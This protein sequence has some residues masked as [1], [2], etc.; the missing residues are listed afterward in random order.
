MYDLKELSYDE[1][2]DRGI[3]YAGSVEL[4]RVSIRDHIFVLVQ[5]KLF[6]DIDEN[7]ELKSEGNFKDDKEDESSKFYYDN[8]KL[9]EGNYKEGKDYM[10]L[11]KTQRQNNQ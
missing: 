4:I 5:Q 1:D 9:E 2:Y 7:G 11:E 8:G 6:G 10:N 3:F